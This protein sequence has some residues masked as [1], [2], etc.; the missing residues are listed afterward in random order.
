MYKKGRW[1]TVIEVKNHCS[2]NFSTDFLINNTSYYSP[3][4]IMINSNKGNFLSDP[5]LLEKIDKLR[6]LNISQHVPLPQVSP[7][8]YIGPLR[9]AI[10]SYMI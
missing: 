7:Q 9:F 10:G 4:V 6:D 3:L 1:F 2:F 8:R 5:E